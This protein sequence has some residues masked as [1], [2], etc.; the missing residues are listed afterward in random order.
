MSR[1]S[2]LL[3]AESSVISGG[4]PVRPGGAIDA[5]CRTVSADRDSAQLT[6]SRHELRRSLMPVGASQ[7]AF[8]QKNRVSRVDRGESGT[9]RSTRVLPLASW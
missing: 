9:E 8:L 7:A 6:R 5:G 3:A 4:C 2:K 1:R